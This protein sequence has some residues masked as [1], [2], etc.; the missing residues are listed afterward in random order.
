MRISINK[1]YLL[2]KLSQ[3]AK[4]AGKENGI[5]PIL[6]NILFTV[7][8]EILRITAG[9]SDI[10]LRTF[11]GNQ[12]FESNQNGKLLVPAKKLHELVNKMGDVIEIKLV[13]D[14]VHIKSGKSQHELS[15][16]DPELY[17]I[18]PQWTSEPV[19]VKGEHLKNAIKQTKFAVSTNENNPILQGIKFHV[20][21]SQLALEGCDRHRLAQIRAEVEN[22]STEATRVVRGEAF[23]HFLPNIPDDKDVSLRFEENQFFIETDDYMFCSRVLDGTYPE[24]GKLIPNSF[25]TEIEVNKAEF[26]AAVER[27]L[28]IALD[29]KTNTVN[30]HSDN[31]DNELIIKSEGQK[32]KAF[33][34]V[35]AVIKGDQLKMSANGKYIVD[36]LKAITGERVRIC[37]N[38][39]LL[40]FIFKGSVESELQL[41]LPY[42]TR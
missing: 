26:Q 25:A 28:I 19:L 41:I 16:E 14:K 18:F 11:I 24:T 31:F 42:R 15:T 29:E 39:G 21:G 7:N 33:E 4:V 30:I 36:A 23:N 35:N 8:D 40:P 10:Y 3:L 38:G 32:N 37:T 22:D 9:D 2:P 13:G 20:T 6:S 5:I 34:A 27:A 12:C 17:P 1:S